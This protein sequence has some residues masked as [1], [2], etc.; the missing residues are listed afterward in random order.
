MDLIKSYHDQE[1][2]SS[3]SD[4]DEPSTKDY[5]APASPQ[6]ST[7]YSTSDK[8]VQSKKISSFKPK[9]NE[10]MTAEAEN[11]SNQPPKNKKPKFNPLVWI[12][13]VGRELR[14]LMGECI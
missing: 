4:D 11:S 6:P 5:T 8:K 3:S 2:L 13:E 14:D 9:L 1:S 7:S 10:L 12:G